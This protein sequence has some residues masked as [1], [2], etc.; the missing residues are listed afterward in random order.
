MS[1]SG[2]LKLTQTQEHIGRF[3]LGKGKQVEERLF[4]VFFAGLKLLLYYVQIT[5]SH[6]QMKVYVN[7]F[8]NKWLT[9]DKL[10]TKIHPYEGIDP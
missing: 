9:L 5:P 10:L 7:Q 3:L 6:I 1:S 2:H 8:V 4:P